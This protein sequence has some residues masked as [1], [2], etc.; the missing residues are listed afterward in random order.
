M[1]EHVYERLG[2]LFLVPPADRRWWETAD[3]RM[4]ATLKKLIVVVDPYPAGTD[5]GRSQAAMRA[6][7]RTQNLMTLVQLGYISEQDVIAGPN[8]EATN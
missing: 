8:E 7:Y 4:E 1:P 2:V 5:A 3:R 6:T